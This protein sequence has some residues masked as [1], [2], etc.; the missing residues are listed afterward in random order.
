MTLDYDVV[1]RAREL[2]SKAE[3]AARAFG[4]P[5]ESL[6]TE[7]RQ[8]ADAIIAAARSKGCDLIFMA[9]H[10]GCERPAQHRRRTRS[11]C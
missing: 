5:C 1:G 8:P 2:L 6:C 3:A 7:G 10:G 9:S 4:V 11:P